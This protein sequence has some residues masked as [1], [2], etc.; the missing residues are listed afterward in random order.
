MPL[1]ESSYRR[2][3]VTG[4]ATAGHILPALEILQV[5]RRDFHATGIFIGCES[6]MAARLVPA[7]GEQLELVPALPWAREGWLSQ[8]RAVAVLP[9]ALREARRLLL[10]HKIQ[11]VIGTGG[12]VS[13]AV[14][15]A[16]H[17]LG[18]PVVIHESNVIPGIANRLIS[19]FADQVC[20]G[21]EET[22]DEFDFPVT[23]TGTPA[24]SVPRAD[25]ESGPP[26]HFIVL[27]G[28]QGSPV[29]NL[30]APSMFGMLRRS[31]VRF[32]VRHVA[33]DSDTGVIA[34]AYKTEGVD[35]QVDG[36]VD[37]MIPVYRQATLAL[38]SAGAKTMAELSAAGIPA[39]LIPLPGAANNHQFANA[40]AYAA[41]GGALLPPE[42][43]LDPES[44]ARQIRAIVER[45]SSL[46]Q[47]R[48]CAAACARPDA[49]ADVVRVCER[50]LQR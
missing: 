3:A 35:V 11:L 17:R 32:S 22:A 21:F 42:G 5:Y 31:G 50:L 26:W 18:L 36:F 40:R 10:R 41:R 33:G 49:A 34:R 19:R 23:A 25:A 6:G 46:R 44:G 9:G 30:D 27:G 14:C 39:I 43:K 8:L 20:V 28:S 29:L 45:E 48:E 16:A 13:F 4:G 2:I 1:D 47:L 7:R 37:D 12:Y 24:G 38:T 15:L